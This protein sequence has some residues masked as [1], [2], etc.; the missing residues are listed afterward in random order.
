MD[1]RMGSVDELKDALLALLLPKPPP[2]P[3]LFE[4]DAADEV[5]GRGN[6]VE[7]G[8]TAAAAKDRACCGEDEVERSED[9][10]SRVAKGDKGGPPA[11]E[12][13][14]PLLLPSLWKTRVGGGGGLGSR[15]G[16]RFRAVQG[17]VKYRCVTLVCRQ[18][19]KHRSD[20]TRSGSKPNG[21]LQATASAT[22]ASAPETYKLP[23]NGPD[24][25][26]AVEEVR[27]GGWYCLTRELEEEEWWEANDP[28]DALLPLED[29]L[30]TVCAEFN[31]AT[32][33]GR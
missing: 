7:D 19:L 12:N 17:V 29:L 26:E 11:P 28:A 32:D 25:K 14:T 30:S 18:V 21:R 1:G 23:V 2:P 5:E 9:F 24:E 10:F 15:A 33:P 31:K 16:E 6:E 4:V 27:G 22:A 3:P 20:P 8:S 13:M